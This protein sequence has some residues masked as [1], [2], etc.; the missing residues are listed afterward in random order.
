G[1]AV[2]L[3]LQPGQVRLAGR[4]VA[5]D[6]H[7]AGG[8]VDRVLVGADLRADR[9]VV[10]VD[11]DDAALAVG[12]RDVLDHAVAERGRVADDVDGADVLAPLD[13]FKGRLDRVELRRVG[14]RDDGDRAP[15]REGQ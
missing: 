5:V 3:E 12:E 9:V 13:L 1:G 15:V 8:G 2:D 14:G 10:A 6:R 7:D 4:R 11:R